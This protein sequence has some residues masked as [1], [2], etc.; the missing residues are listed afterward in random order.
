MKRILLLLLPVLAA[1]CITGA[2][3]SKREGRF[4]FCARSKKFNEKDVA[5]LYALT[6]DA[7][8]KALSYETLLAFCNNNLFPLGEIK[9]LSFEKETNGICKYKSVFS[10]VSLSLFLGL[11][12]TDK[13]ETFLF[14]PYVDEKAKKIRSSI[15][16]PVG[17]PAGQGSG[18][19][20]TRLYESAAN[21]GP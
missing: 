19:S 9:E 1:A 2:K 18:F 5:G 15:I 20:S 4:C 12:K 16:E 13:I 10:T 3:P 8:K 21:Y 11:D 7:F 6:G 17:I 14:K